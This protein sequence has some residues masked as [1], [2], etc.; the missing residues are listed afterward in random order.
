MGRFFGVFFV[1]VLWSKGYS[2]MKAEPRSKEKS[3][4]A[5]HAAVS[6]TL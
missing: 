1:C 6:L 5:F 3:M 2:G 4:G